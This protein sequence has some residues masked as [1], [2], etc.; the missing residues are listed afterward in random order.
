LVSFSVEMFNHKLLGPN[1]LDY[2]LLLRQLGKKD[3]QQLQNHIVTRSNRY[4]SFDQ[5]LTSEIIITKKT[6]VLI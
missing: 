4:E 6:T 1:L 2:K 3:L 5:K